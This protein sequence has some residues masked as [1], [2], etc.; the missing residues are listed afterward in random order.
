MSPVDGVV[1]RVACDIARAS[2][3]R[4][5]GFIVAWNGVLA[6][7]YDGW[8]GTLRELKA[9]LNAP[10]IGLREESPGSA[11][12]KTSLACEMEHAAPMTV[13]Q[14]RSLTALME[15]F[16]DEARSVEVTVRELAVVV[17]GSRCCEKRLSVKRVRLK[18]GDGNQDV[19][20]ES[21]AVVEKVFAEAGGE[22][23]LERINRPGHRSNHYESGNGV[24]LVCDCGDVI[25]DVVRRFREEVDAILP[26][27]YRWFNHDALHITIRGLV[28]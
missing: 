16:G 17:F 1:E 21:R 20:E 26:G 5:R 24:T 10:E 25:G 14:R 12:P 19:S 9:A 7:G 28:N 27:R 3:L 23:Y 6:L 4:G 11:W 15:A 13:D 2:T 8:S 18:E 22:D